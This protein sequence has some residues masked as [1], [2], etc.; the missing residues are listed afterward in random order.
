MIIK[1]LLIIL[2]HTHLLKLYLGEN[3]STQLV[4]KTVNVFILVQQETNGDFFKKI[5]HHMSIAFYIGI[6]QNSL[7]KS[8]VFFKGMCSYASIWQI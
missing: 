2:L 3:K 5:L 4:S 7:S 6:F 8:S 1:Q